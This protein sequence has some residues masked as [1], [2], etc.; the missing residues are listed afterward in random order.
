MTQGLRRAAKL[1]PERIALISEG[2]QSNLGEII[3]ASS[4][5]DFSWFDLDYSVRGFRIENRHYL[6]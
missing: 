1:M 3:R 2:S 6:N 4:Q 5:I